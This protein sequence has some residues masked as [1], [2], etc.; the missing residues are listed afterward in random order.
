MK[1]VKINGI[2]LIAE[3]IQMDLRKNIVV[4]VLEHREGTVKEFIDDEEVLTINGSVRGKGKAFDLACALND[5]M[6]LISIDMGEIKEGYIMSY[7]LLKRK[8]SMYP[9]KITA[10][11]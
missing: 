2:T 3:H 11:A 1:T 7:E 8:G 5:D 4:T 9:F 10:V 6:A